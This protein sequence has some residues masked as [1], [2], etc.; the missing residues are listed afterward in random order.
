MLGRLPGRGRSDAGLSGGGTWREARTPWPQRP[1]VRAAEAARHA[2]L[3]GNPGQEETTPLLT[4]WRAHPARPPAGPGLMVTP[5]GRLCGRSPS[6]S[7]RLWVPSAHLTL[8]WFPRDRHAPRAPGLCVGSGDAAWRGAGS[9]QPASQAAERVA[10]RWAGVGLG[11]PGHQQSGHNRTQAGEEERVAWGASGPPSRL[12]NEAQRSEGTAGLGCQLP[13]A[14]GCDCPVWA[15]CGP[16][17]ALGPSWEA[18][19]CGRRPLGDEAVHTPAGTQRLG[20]REPGTQEP[21]AWHPEAW[22]QRARDSGALGSTLG[23]SPM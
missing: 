7:R 5:S 1:L 9:S 13:G 22:A 8:C 15:C 6:A 2:V 14:P 23:R 3:P 16:G 10:E 12:E 17:P 20:H 18:P 19:V 4:A 11:C 21:W